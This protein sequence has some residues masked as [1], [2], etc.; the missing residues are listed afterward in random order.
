[1][2]DRLMPQTD[3][4]TRMALAAADAA[5]ADAGAGPG[6]LPEYDMGVATASTSGG[7]EFGQRELQKLWGKG[8]QHV[9][10]YMSFAWYYAVNTGQ[11]SI[12]HGMRGPGGVVISEQ[13]G[14]LDALAFARRQI[15]KGTPLM[16]TGGVDGSLCPYGLAIQIASGRLSTQDHPDLAYLP[17]DHRANGYLP[18]EGG[19]ILVA[20]ERESAQR[21]GA[22][23]AGE[24]AGYGAAFDPSPGS[25]GA[26]VRAARAALADAGLAAD[27]IDA[28]V[29][30][31]AGQ[32]DDDQA[33]ADAL[34]ELFGPAGVPVCVPKT[35]TG[36]LLS[37]G[38]AL[39]TATALLALRDQVLPPAINIH[40]ELTD[41]RLDL[42]IGEPRETPVRAVL[43]LARGHGG[44]ASAAVLTRP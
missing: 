27:G 26:L 6:T 29:A 28:V 43:V 7:L 39:D 17:F 36:R 4:M 23:A 32:Q 15:R 3:R 11:I 20:E 31:A 40:A 8:W 21:R 41:P 5:L 16:V 18:G 13:A 44:F 22:P 10:A 35:M 25:R 19:A 2:P 14:G 38:A 1:V 34:S 37:G 42:V 24:L 30:D 33:E 12:K 9:S